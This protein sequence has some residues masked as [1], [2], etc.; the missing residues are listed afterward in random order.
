MVA[1]GLSRLTDEVPTTKD[2][3]PVSHDEALQGV[4]EVVT[5]P[6][7]DDNE[8]LQGVKEV[9][10]IPSHDS[11]AASRGPV[12]IGTEP[13][14]PNTYRK[15]TKRKRKREVKMDQEVTD[16]ERSVESVVTPLDTSSALSSR[17]D[18]RDI[19][20]EENAAMEP[21]VRMLTNLAFAPVEQGMSQS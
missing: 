15:E 2:S 19:D 21:T 12:G 4:K 8:A 16:L 18:H 17:R 10:G 1:D 11:T 13:Q 14:L 7:D 3:W 5:I 9:E 6:S 20:A